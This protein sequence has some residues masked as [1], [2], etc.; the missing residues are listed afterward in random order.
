MRVLLILGLVLEPTWLVKTEVVLLLL[1]ELLKVKK[2]H[3]CH[4]IVVKGLEKVNQ[5]FRTLLAHTGTLFCVL[6]WTL[7]SKD[8]VI[9]DILLVLNLRVIWGKA[10]TTLRK[11]LAHGTYSADI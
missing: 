11:L 5:F 9:G 2:S 4:V 7:S 8:V 3:T 1:L 10:Y 6:D